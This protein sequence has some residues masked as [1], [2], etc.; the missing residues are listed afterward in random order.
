MH[1][2]RLRHS[3]WP[4]LWE[5]REDTAHVSIEIS[6]P[7]ASCESAARAQMAPLR[8]RSAAHRASIMHVTTFLWHSPLAAHDAQFGLASL[9]PYA[10][11]ASLETVRPARISALM[12]RRSHCGGSS[13]KLATG[14][15]LIIAC[16]GAHSVTH[17]SER[18][19]PKSCAAGSSAVACHA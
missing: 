2:R 14:L 3:L 7:S 12:E 9:Q 5:M 10:S 15:I 17:L 1:H 4:I 6:N 18:T 8:P 16:A 19:S 13:R 11:L